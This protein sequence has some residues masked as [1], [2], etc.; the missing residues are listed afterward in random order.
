MLCGKI[1]GYP[2]QLRAS[3]ACAVCPLFFVFLDVFFAT[4][5]HP[6]ALPAGREAFFALVRRLACALRVVCTWLRLTVRVPVGEGVDNCRTEK[7]SIK[8]IEKL[9]SRLKNMAGICGICELI[10]I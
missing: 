7:S 6:A 3:A 5:S 10:N 8:P 2:F 1:I 4:F 9:I